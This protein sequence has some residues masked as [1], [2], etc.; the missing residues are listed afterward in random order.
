MRYIKSVS[1]HANT[2]PLL[3][4]HNP[5]IT[6]ININMTKLLND[7]IGEIDTFVGI[8]FSD[9]N[10]SE[11]VSALQVNENKFTVIIGSDEI[12]VGAFASGFNT[13]MG[14]TLNFLPKVAQTIHEAV[15]LGVIK[16]A[17]ESQLL[18]T[19]TIYAICRQGDWIP[20]MKAAMNL[21]SPIFVGPV[22]G[23]LV[24]V[25]LAKIQK[26]KAELQQLK[27]IT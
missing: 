3:Y 18:L 25:W 13:L 5:T 24:D 12:M 15:K 6:G 1:D 2:L 16:E 9:N 17:R 26:M 4:H 7:I 14:T 10:L 23:P 11:A 20:A 21:M 8:I 22:R 19:N 27:V